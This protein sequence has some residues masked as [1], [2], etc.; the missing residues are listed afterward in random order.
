MKYGI[1]LAPIT[2]NGTAYVP[3]SQPFITKYGTPLAP[4]TKYGTAYV[5]RS[6]THLL[7]NMELLFPPLLN[8]EQLMR[9]DHTPI[10]YKIWDSS[11]P[12]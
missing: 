4:I 7:Q 10:Y 6:Y 5:P 1:P 3:R 8:M 2:K 12:H 11:C 9:Q